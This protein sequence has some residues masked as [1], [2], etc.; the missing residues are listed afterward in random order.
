MAIHTAAAISA[1]LTVLEAATGPIEIDATGAFFAG[2][3]ITDFT[4]PCCA[5]IDAD[6]D[7]INTRSR[8]LNAFFFGTAIGTTVAGASTG[9]PSPCGRTFQALGA[10]IIAVA[11]FTRRGVAALNAQGHAAVV[12]VEGAAGGAIG[13]GRITALAGLVTTSV[14]FIA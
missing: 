5:T 11:G 10:G 13:T 14:V 4:E 12:A 9:P 1:R 2:L 7:G 8:H 6:L 3:G